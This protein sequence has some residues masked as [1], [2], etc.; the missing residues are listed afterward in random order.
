MP[1]KYLELDSNYR[2]RNLEGNGKPGSFS[3]QISQTG[4]ATQLTALDPITYAYPINNFSIKDS[5][6]ISFTYTPPTVSTYFSVSSPTKFI[7]TTTNTYIFPNGYFVGA[8]LVPQTGLIVAPIGIRI[9]EWIFMNNDT[10]TYQYLVSTETL[11]I[12]TTTT[13]CN[14][15]KLSSPIQ[16]P[17]IIMASPQYIF[18]PTSLSIPNYYSKYILY[19]QSLQNHP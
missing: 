7:L 15:F 9:L 12:P 1:I 14:I 13:T 2:N 10:T 4:M 8:V 17:P 5:E 19:N 3:C 11:F 6:D 18:L 16:N